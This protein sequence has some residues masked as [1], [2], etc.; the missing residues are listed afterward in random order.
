MK[1]LYVTLRITMLYHY[2]EC[3]CAECR[4]LFIILVNVIM[5]NVIMPSVVA[6]LESRCMQECHNLCFQLNLVYSQ[7]APYRPSAAIPST[8]SKP[9]NAFYSF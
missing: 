7:L 4:V 9:V 6:Q 5:L 2:V 3:H 1:G 8:S